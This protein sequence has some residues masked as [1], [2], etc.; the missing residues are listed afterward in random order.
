MKS[1]FMLQVGGFAGQRTVQGTKRASTWEKN[2]GW[3]TEMVEVS[4]ELA[5]DDG[6]VWLSLPE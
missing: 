5:A 1:A 3:G 2:H 4:A 6:N